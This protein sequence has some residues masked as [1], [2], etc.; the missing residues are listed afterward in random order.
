[1]SDVALWPIEPHTQAKHALLK[2]YLDR[3]FPILGKHNTRINYIDGFAGPGKY[4]GGESG[5]PILAIQ[6]AADHLANGTLLPNV[7]GNFIFVERSADHIS[8]LRR[9]VAELS[10]PS[11]FKFEFVEG[12]FRGHLDDIITKIEA[13]VRK[14]APTFA[15]VDPF[16]FSGIP[17]S[18]MARPC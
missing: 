16:G 8:Q 18:L 17:M 10:P 11:Q 6:S 9:Q 4:S 2:L 13:A 3:W 14:L 1:M 15:F 7:E 5:S 12:H